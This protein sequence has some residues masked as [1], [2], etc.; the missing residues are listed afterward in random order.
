MSSTCK[1]I[2]LYGVLSLNVF[3]NNRSYGVEIIPKS[4]LIA[5]F[6]T[7]S[8]VATHNHQRRVVV[9]A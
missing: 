9:F 3:K 1:C 7:A 8:M 2:C 6:Q 4:Q 5:I